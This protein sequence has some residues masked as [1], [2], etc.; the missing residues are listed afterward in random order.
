MNTSEL[1]LLLKEGEGLST[2]FKESFSGKLDRDMVA[3]SNTHGGRIFLGVGDLGEIVGETLTNDLK[4]KINSL[5][6]NCEPSITLKS[7]EQV[8]ETVVI[9]IDESGEK[10]HSCSSGYYRR[11]DAAT[12]K[13]NQKELKILFKK[14]EVSTPFERQ[15]CGNISFDDIS[16]DKV[17]A[18]LSAAKIDIA[19][20]SHKEILDSLNLSQNNKINNA[21]VILFAKNPKQYVFHCETILVAFKGTDRV[22][23]YDRMNVQDDLITQFNEAIAF[24]RKHL[25]VRSEIKGVERNDICEIPLEALREAVANAIIHRDYAI[26][27]TSL[28]IEVHEDRVRIKNPGGIPA[29]MDINLLMRTSV[30]RNELIADIFSRIGRAERMASGLPRI[31]RLM[32]EA[33]LP[34][35]IIESNSFFEIIFE[36]DKRYSSAKEY[37]NYSNQK[38]PSKD[39]SLRQAEILK[40]LTG[41]K[42]RTGELMALLDGQVAERT[43]RRDLGIL[44]DKGYL[45][46]EGPAGWERKWF[47]VER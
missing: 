12:Q 45:D 40:V 44:K 23:I 18:F 39:L 42:L 31:M 17:K 1:H 33:E 30:R 47:V 34:K 8:D 41:K 15:V 22:H 19:S 7:I 16:E 10:P 26:S 24:L 32:S 46:F 11:L 5:A 43:L 3:F 14:S 36:R 37:A 2:E 38:E 25:N 29:G 4:A 13:M 35:P 6:R 21:G 20:I 9:T 28:M 27:G